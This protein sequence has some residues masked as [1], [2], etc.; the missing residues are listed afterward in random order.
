MPIDVDVT[1]SSLYVLRSY[2]LVFVGDI[3]DKDTEIRYDKSYIKSSKPWEVKERS[4]GS[5]SANTLLLNRHFRYESAS[6]SS[7]FYFIRKWAF[8]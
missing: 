4:R 8:F 1:Y 2:G 5:A 7:L 6:I 3:D